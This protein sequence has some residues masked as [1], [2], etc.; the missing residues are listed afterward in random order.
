MEI[1]EGFSF[2]P[3]CDEYTEEINKKSFDKIEL[4]ASTIIHPSECVVG[5]RFKKYIKKILEFEVYPD[6]TWVISFPKS[7]KFYK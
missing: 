2:E 4:N 3:I 5:S 7:G 1:I 6:D